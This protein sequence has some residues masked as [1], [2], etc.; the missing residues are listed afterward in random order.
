MMVYIYFLLFLTCVSSLQIGYFVPKD[1][2]K[3]FYDELNGYTTHINGGDPVKKIEVVKSTITYDGGNETLSGIFDEFKEQSISLVLSYCDDVI[4]DYDFSV[5]HSDIVVWCSNPI[6]PRLCSVNIIPGDMI[7][8]SM[9][10]GIHMNIYN[11][12]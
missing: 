4:Y 7:G 10:T 3:D 5:K 6:P 11:L 12:I 8:Y 2:T 1:T 9:E